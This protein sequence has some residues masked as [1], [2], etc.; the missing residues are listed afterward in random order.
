MFDVW[1]IRL[2]QMN[3]NQIYKHYNMEKKLSKALDQIQV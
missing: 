2:N 1:E 3:Y